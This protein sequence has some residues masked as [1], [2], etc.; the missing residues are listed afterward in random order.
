M[1]IYVNQSPLSILIHF[2]SL[3]FS[4]LNLDS[5]LQFIVLDLRTHFQ[6]RNDTGGLK[7]KARIFLYF[8]F[9]NEFFNS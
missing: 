4:T 8:L 9:L 5:I 3:L 2:G 1:I 6:E 7:G